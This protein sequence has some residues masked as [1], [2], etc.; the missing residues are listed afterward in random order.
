MNKSEGFISSDVG[1]ERGDVP[2]DEAEGNGCDV[3]GLNFVPHPG[4]VAI[5]WADFVEVVEEDE[6]AD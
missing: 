5:I 4:A 3:F 6:A 1:L 2:Y